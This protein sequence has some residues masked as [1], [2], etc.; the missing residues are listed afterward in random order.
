[1]GLRWP[2]SCLAVGWLLLTAADS[3][4]AQSA[5]PSSSANPSPAGS[6]FESP[7]PLP[8]PSL[9]HSPTGSPSTSPSPS[10][11][12]SPTPLSGQ[13]YTSA[14]V[15]STIN[16]QVI[17]AVNSDSLTWTT[18]ATAVAPAMGLDRGMLLPVS[19]AQAATAD[20]TKVVFQVAKTSNVQLMRKVEALQA[21]IVANVTLTNALPLM[22]AR[23]IA[24]DF[25][26]VQ[27]GFPAWLIV[28]IVIMVLLSLICLKCEW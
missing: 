14:D 17:V 11:S 4:S 20:E 25:Q 6:P 22:E 24:L 27:V 10:P 13:N 15:I 9:S 5:S 12:P 7:S 26:V 18:F 16:V 1:M 23:L 21:Q 19:L 2:L 8:G 3:A 28:G